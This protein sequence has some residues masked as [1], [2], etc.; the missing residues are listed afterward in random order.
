MSSKKLQQQQLPSGMADALGADEYEDDSDEEVLIEGESSSGE[1]NSEDEEDSQDEGS[2]ES[3]DNAESK[4]GTPVKSLRSAE[5]RARGRKLEEEDPDAFRGVRGERRFEGDENVRAEGYA[6]SD[7]EHEKNTIGN[8]PLHWYDEFDHIGYDRAGKKIGRSQNMDEVDKFLASKDDPFYRRTFYDAKNDRSIVLTDR[9]LIMARRMMEGKFP[10]QGFD[11]YPDYIDFESGEKAVMPIADPYEPKRRFVPSKFERMK[12]LKLMHGI[13]AGYVK[14]GGLPPKEKTAKPEVYLLW[15]D[16]DMA[17][18]IKKR[19]KAPKHIP[20]PKVTPPDHRESYHPPVEYLPTEEEAKEWQEAHPDDRKINYLPHDFS[21]MRRIPAYDDYVKERFERCLDLYLA[22]R[23]EVKRINIDPES[24]VPKLP[25]PSELRPFPNTVAVTYFGH[26]S[27]VRTLA[28]DPS[29]ELLASGGDDLILRIWEVESGRCLMSRDLSKY[30]TEEVAAEI[31]KG[32]EN[33]D[34]DKEAEEPVVN[35]GFISR[36]AWN[37][38]SKYRVVAVAVGDNI[39]LVDVSEA[40]FASEDDVETTQQLMAGALSANGPDSEDNG[41]EADDD[42]EDADTPMMNEDGEE[43]Q[44]AK[45]NQALRASRKMVGWKRED[46]NL[47]MIYFKEADRGSVQDLVWHSKGEYLASVAN[48]KV[49]N[50]Q[51]TVHHVLK[52]MSQRPLR[53]PKDHRVQR[54]LFHPRKP[55]LFV[56]SK[57]YVHVYHLVRQKRMSQLMTGAQWISSIA[58]HPDG[59]NLVVGTYDRRMI[60]FDLD[61]SNKPWRTLRYHKK[62]LRD[63]DFHQRYPLFASASDD[64]CVHVFH[65]RVFEDFDKDPYLIPVKVLRGHEQTLD[66]LGVLAIAFHPTQPWLFSAGA[67]GRLQLFQNIG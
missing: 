40:S 63:V 58:I 23:K 2:G 55:I 52:R 49:A 10:E 4:S 43:D 48:T 32:T 31:T 16:D 21:Q 1:D 54:I 29:G 57:I 42:D 65:A 64:G 67:D 50:S 18:D 26:H 41:A 11:P 3:D 9:E 25:Q 56:A 13:R 20:A 38:Q 22:P 37:P 47:V 12:V 15:G 35:K 28:V 60:W 6:S 53:F 17:D 59:N 36:I 66:G 44:Q 61:L 8:V 39:I 27:R 24:L 7:E 46:D 5:A 34:D 62:A 51:V 45:L 33:E 14:R 30:A 19:R